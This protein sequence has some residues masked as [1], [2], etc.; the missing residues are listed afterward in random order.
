MFPVLRALKHLP[1]GSEVL[2][3]LHLTVSRTAI[4]GPPCSCPADSSPSRRGFSCSPPLSRCAWGPARWQ[5]PPQLPPALR[6]Q[7]GRGSCSRRCP[8]AASCSFRTNR[9]GAPSHGSYHVPLL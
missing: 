8:L 1:R 5:L 6:P 7:S 2:L 9:S 3:I 4:V